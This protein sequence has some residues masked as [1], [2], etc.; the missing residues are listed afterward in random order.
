MVT[1]GLPDTTDV[2]PMKYARISRFCIHF[3]MTKPRIKSKSVPFSAQLKIFNDNISLYADTAGRKNLGMGCTYRVQWR[4][5]LWSETDLFKDG[6]KPN[7]T[8][9]ELLAIVA[10]LETWAEELAGKH[11]ILHS[12]NS[13]T[14]AFINKM[15][16]DI[17]AAMDLLC[18]VSKTCL[19]FQIWL[20]AEHLAGSLNMNWTTFPETAWICTSS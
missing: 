20:K 19:S 7:I 1:D 16:S 9:L 6:F 5:G 12:D 14:V 2:F 4:Q 11:I 10:A 18:L 17:P 13:V 8:L 15:K 3:W